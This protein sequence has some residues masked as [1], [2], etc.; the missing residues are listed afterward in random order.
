MEEA[1]KDAGRGRVAAA[2]RLQAGIPKIVALIALVAVVGLTVTSCGWLRDIPDD[3]MWS[4]KGGSDGVPLYPDDKSTYVKDN[5]SIGTPQTE[6]KL[7][8]PNKTDVLVLKSAQSWGGFYQVKYKDSTYIMIAKNI[9]K[10]SKNKTVSQAERDS[11]RDASRASHKE[12]RKEKNKKDAAGLAKF[13]VGLAIVSAVFFYLYKW[14]KSRSSR[15]YKKYYAQKRREFPWLDQWMQQNRDP[16]EVRAENS[17]QASIAW[18]VFLF[19]GLMILVFVLGKANLTNTLVFLA[20]SAG[21][22]WLMGM[23]T[24]KGAGKDS[25]E[26]GLT[27]ECP[28]CH[29]PHA[30]VM[31]QRETII[32]SKR[33]V[34]KTRSGYGRGDG[35]DS[36]FEGFKQNGTT[37]STVYN[38]R[39]IKDFQCLNCGR[40][41]HEEYSEQSSTSP[42]AGIIVFNPPISAFDQIVNRLQ[43]NK[44][45]EKQ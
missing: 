45:K 26:I 30:W 21:L 10:P 32:D 3:S 19:T 24:L 15:V 14:N 43:E 2:S 34:T 13:L 12:W 29:C 18:S 28:A 17:S 5:V 31:T 25:V 39:R 27:M 16:V 23:K 35:M 38:S 1:K 11:T 6:P 22:C 20:I 40:V 4:V 42:S 36:M 44:T 41:K 33:T 9:H 8:I 7:T 37:S